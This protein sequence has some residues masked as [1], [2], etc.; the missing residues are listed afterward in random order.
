[1][2][3]WLVPRST[4]QQQQPQ[5][6]PC[7][8]CLRAQQ[9][10]PRRRQLD[11]QRQP[12]QPGADLRHRPGV[13]LRQRKVRSRGSGAGDDESIVVTQYDMTALEKAGM[14]KMDFLGLT[15]LTVLHDT[16]EMIRE[17]SG[18]A[19]DLVNLPLDDQATYR[20]LR[21]GR[22][23]GVFQ[24][25]SPLATDT[26][27]S[28]HCDRFDDLVAANALLRPGP[29]DA[30]MHRVYFRR[31]RGDLRCHYLSGAGNAHRPAPVGNVTR[32]GG[33][34]AEGCG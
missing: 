8:Q 33:R 4:R 24:F 5:L 3:C 19:P 20:M 12:V 16:V 23:V 26:L 32:R 7:E 10:Q 21:S 17:R 29:L 9:T 34:G 15:T 27:R 30:G 6:Q 18:S 14:L 2:P 25:E 31:K 11:G 28:M 1:V 22:T 13:A